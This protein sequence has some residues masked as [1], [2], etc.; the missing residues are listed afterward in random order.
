MVRARLDQLGRTL[1]VTRESRDED[2]MSYADQLEAIY[3]KWERRVKEQ[4]IRIGFEKG[5][6]RG[7]EKGLDIGFDNGF[8]QGLVR[9]LRE[10]LVRLYHGRFGALPPALWEAIEATEDVPTLRSWLA[11]FCAASAD[12]LAAALLSDDAASRS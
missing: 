1:E 2:A 8:E 9:G 6:D 3:A 5:L 10:G 11:L 12:D 4:G 7:F